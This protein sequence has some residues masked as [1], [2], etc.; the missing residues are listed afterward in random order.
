MQGA[1]LF[2]QFRKVELTKQMRAA[3][4]L[5]HTRLIDA[6]QKPEPNM[7]WIVE[8]LET[9]YQTLSAELLKVDPAF[10]FCPIATTGKRELSTIAFLKLS[11]F[12]SNNTD[13]FG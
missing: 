8:Q 6:M 11:Q 9:Q 1:Q 5:Q 12:S 2:I 10:M 7:D 4:D 13:S 3:G